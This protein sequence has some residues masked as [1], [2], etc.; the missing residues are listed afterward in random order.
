MKEA[1]SNQSNDKPVS[2]SL[3]WMDLLKHAGIDYGIHYRE[4]DASTLRKELLRKTAVDLNIDF[5]RQRIDYMGVHLLTELA[6]SRN[7]PQAIKDMF[8]GKKVNT[9][10]DRSALHIALRAKESEEIYVDGKDVVPEVH[11]VRR[12]MENFAFDILEGEWRGA[13]GKPIKHIVSIG[14]GGSNLGPEMAY[15]ALLQY[16]HPNIEV[17]FVANVDPND[18]N[19]IIRPLDTTHTLNP[20]ETLFIISSKT[21][22][23]T[24]TMQN[25]Q[26]ARKWLVDALG[27]DAVAKHFVA[28]STNKEA[29]EKFGIN[30]ENMFEMW[31]WVGGRYSVTSAIGLPVMLSIGVDNF[32]QFLAGARRMDQHYLHTSME[33]N[34][35]VL[36]ALFNIWNN[37]FLHIPTHP[38]IPYDER[39]DLFALHLQ[40]LSME[41]LGKRVT[42][43]GVPLNIDA[44]QYLIPGIGTNMQHSWMQQ[45]QVGA[46]TAIDF[47]AFLKPIHEEDID[48][49][50]SLLG[51]MVAQATVMSRGVTEEELRVAGKTDDRLLAHKAMP[52][53]RPSTIIYTNEL[54]PNTLGQLLALYEHSVHAQGVILGVNPFDQWGV[55]AGKVI[56]K[57]LGKKTVPGVAFT[58]ETFK[59]LLDS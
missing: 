53:N 50:N 52:G 27:E 41:S 13:T 47:I 6:I 42:Q 55:E 2:E 51:N 17:H 8:M 43:N 34:V 40:Q 48:Q 49:H 9:T 5:T 59:K 23:T 31:D 20:E 3:C 15:K 54:T 25:A 58:P 35:P 1:Y 4:L 22:T 32:N 24:E 44:N 57:E 38:I 12:K 21:F 26:K 11:A 16:K 56:A 45:V 46:P 14:I 39:L 30:S 28:V 10:E 29:V 37:N 19:E 18:I 36:M 33:Y 7:L